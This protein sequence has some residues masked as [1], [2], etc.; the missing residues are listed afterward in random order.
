MWVLLSVALVPL[1]GGGFWGAGVP[2]GVVG[3]SLSS[4]IATCGYG[5]ML[6]RLMH[7]APEALGPDATTPAGM[8]RR[9][10]LGRAAFWIV[11]IGA[12]GFGV[13]ALVSGAGRVAGSPVSTRDAGALPSE[14][15]PTERFYKVS[16]NF[17][18]PK[19]DGKGW[20]LQVT[21]MVDRAMSLTLDEL[22]ALPAVEH[23][24]A[25]ECVSNPVGGDLIGNAAWKGVPLRDLLQSAGLKPNVAR[26]TFRSAD[27]YTESLPLEDAM[28]PEILIAY[29]MNGE[30]LRN[31]HGFPAHVLIPDRYGMKSPK[32][33][34]EIGTTSDK[35]YRG[36]WEER[37]WDDRAEVKTT[38]QALV[39]A[40]GTVVP[41]EASVI[42]GIAFSG[43][44]GITQVEVS[45]N[46]GKSWQKATLK[47]ALSPYT[48]VLW[49]VEWE[50]TAPGRYKLTVRA[51]DGKGVPQISTPHDPAP[52]GATGYHVIDVKVTEPKG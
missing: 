22:R 6:S 24:Q 38:S 34:E 40:D 36:Y 50:P 27:G 43:A 32:W 14:V 2:G 8:T 39:P 5:L 7:P 33:L 49:T 51:E 15:T 31:D 3:F 21:G 48:W 37:G 46:G 17:V 42:G 52:S 29:E 25:L 47:P 4:F 1:L 26:M 11:A 18:D 19:V 16:K 41:V 12:V 44:K 9:T 13:R 23:Y 10:F 45:A 30:P 35:N 28:R 20:R